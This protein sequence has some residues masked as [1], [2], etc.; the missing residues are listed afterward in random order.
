MV[1]PTPALGELL[2]LGQSQ[3]EVCRGAAG[4]VAGHDNPADALG[5]EDACGP[6]RLHHSVGGVIRRVELFLVVVLVSA[7]VSLGSGLTRRAQCHTRQGV[8]RT[9]ARVW[10]PNEQG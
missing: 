4:T 6:P 1:V 2:L 10:K 8:I 5:R 9:A 7:S 3:V